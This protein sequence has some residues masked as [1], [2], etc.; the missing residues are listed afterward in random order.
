[1]FTV[2]VEGFYFH[3]ITLRHTAVCRTPL[4]E[5]SARP[6]DIYLTTINTVQETNIHAPGNIRT[7]DPN[8]RSAAD[9][10]LTPRGHCDHIPK[11]RV[12]NA[13][14]VLMLNKT[15]LE[16]NIMLVQINKAPYCGI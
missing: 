8:K 1:L 2:G 11:L 4:D 7:H 3:L 6:R 16:A 15:V 9:L 12:F 14:K 13:Q 5:G 10:R